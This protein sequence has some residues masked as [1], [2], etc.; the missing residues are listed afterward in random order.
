M[1]NSNQCPAYSDVR[2]GEVHIQRVQR[3]IGWCSSILSRNGGEVMILFHRFL[4]LFV[5]VGA[6]FAGMFNAAAR[7]IAIKEQ[8]FV[9]YLANAPLEVIAETKVSDL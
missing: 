3:R 9:Y 7:D 6:L 4:L 1:H 5:C 8:A 2:N